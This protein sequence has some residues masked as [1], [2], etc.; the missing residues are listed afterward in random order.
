VDVLEKR[1]IYSRAGNWTQVRPDCSLQS[2][3]SPGFNPRTVH[4]SFVVDKLALGLFYLQILWFSPVSTF[5]Q[6]AIFI[7]TSITDSIKS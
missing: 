2:T 5:C 1:K 4:V 7:H 3:Q 6:G